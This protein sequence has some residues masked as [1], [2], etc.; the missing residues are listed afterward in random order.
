M[1]VGTPSRP[2]SAIHRPPL[3]KNYSYCNM[4]SYCNNYT[5]GKWG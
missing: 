2:P 5:F 1:G 4:Y 3:G